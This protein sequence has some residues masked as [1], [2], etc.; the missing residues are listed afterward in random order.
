MTSATQWPPEAE[1][2]RQRLEH[3]LRN[4]AMVYEMT[5]ADVQDCLNRIIMSN[6]VEQLVQFV[7]GS[8]SQL[9]QIAHLSLRIQ[10]SKLELEAKSKALQAAL[11]GQR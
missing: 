8:E 11:E 10:Q 3:R 6:G 5:E 2:F 9:E 1:L 7:A 4:Q